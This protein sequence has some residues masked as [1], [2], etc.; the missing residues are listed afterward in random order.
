M[1][2]GVSVPSE[3]G[4]A[5]RPAS[6]RRVTDLADLRCSEKFEAPCSPMQ[7]DK[8]PSES[9]SSAPPVRAFR[10]LT[11]VRDDR[12]LHNLLRS[13]R[14]SL[15]SAPDYFRFVQREIAPPMRKIVADWML[16]V[17][18]EL[19]CQPEVFALAMNYFDRFLAR[20][21][22]RKGTLQLLGSVCL[23][24]ASKFKETC[25]IL[26]EK[27]IFYSDFSIGSDELKV[28]EK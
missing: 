25:P 12:I 5:S 18:Q 4:P 10:D 14:R 26:G 21:R 3:D 17:C 9:S 28:G 22:V 8:A 24:L 7:Q 16:Q 20:C 1:A 27:L 2:A 23:L 15:P 11:L 13:E 19:Q 6:V